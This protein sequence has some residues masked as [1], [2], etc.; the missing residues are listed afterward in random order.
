MAA[1]SRPLT[2]EELNAG[3]NVVK[4]NFFKVGV[5]LSASV[6]FSTDGLEVDLSLLEI[7]SFKPGPDEGTVI[8]TGHF[9]LLGLGVDALDKTRATLEAGG[10]FNLLT[11]DAQHCSRMFAAGPVLMGQKD[12]KAAGPSGVEMPHVF[13]GSL[14]IGIDAGVQTNGLGLSIRGPNYQ[15]P[16]SSFSLASFNFDAF[17]NTGLRTKAAL[18]LGVISAGADSVYGVFQVGKDC[19]MR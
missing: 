5:D 16:D 8:K 12:E 6:N 15:S 14:W 9:E 3:P 7:K 13:Q 19:F 1:E 10:K 17:R 4:P 11:A 2:E 18:D